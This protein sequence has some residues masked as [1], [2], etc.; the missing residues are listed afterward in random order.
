M[1]AWVAWFKVEAGV[2]TVPNSMSKPLS[3]APKLHLGVY[4]LFL[5]NQ[6]FCAIIGSCA[7]KEDG[8]PRTFNSIYK[9]YLD[10]RPTLKTFVNN[11]GDKTKSVYQLTYNDFYATALARI[12]YKDNRGRVIIITFIIF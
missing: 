1:Y 8:T 6:A 4:R 5:S 3:L 10:Y 12:K 9:N 11:L 7:P 2:G